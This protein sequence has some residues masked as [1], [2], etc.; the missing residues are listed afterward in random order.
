H[1]RRSKIPVVVPRKVSIITTHFYG[2]TAARPGDVVQDL[3]GAG[4]RVLSVA[5]TRALKTSNA[6]GRD[7]GARRRRPGNTQTQFAENPSSGFI[8]ISR[9]VGTRITR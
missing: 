2:M 8:E 5:C 6:E 3:A 9:R 4:P 1:A 7:C